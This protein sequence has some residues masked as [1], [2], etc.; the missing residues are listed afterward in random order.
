MLASLATDARCLAQATAGTPPATPAL[1]RLPLLR[2]GSVVSR[3]SGDITQDPDDRLWIFRPTQSESGGIRREF[4]LL[5]SPVL[6]D[7]VRLMRLSPSPVEFEVTGRVFIYH[8]HNYL[9]PELA[10]AIVRFDAKPGE[11]PKP[12]DDA[13]AAP[14]GE[15]RFVPP[16]GDDDDAIVRDIEKRLEERVGQVPT[17]RPSERI[18]PREGSGPKSPIASGTRFVAREGRIAR[19][20]QSGSWRFVPEQRGGS[21][22]PSLEILPCL[23]LESLERA[24][25]QSDASPR[26]VL[27]GTVLAYEGRSYLLPSSFRRARAGIGLGAQ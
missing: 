3:V 27:S 6:E 9:L 13:V 18:A 20:P 16:V 1:Y 23:L 14:S 17:T 22:D 7:M 24:A 4:V 19:D 21:G 15:A 10:P 11:T 25:R 26:I 8:G 5:P 2:E 12:T